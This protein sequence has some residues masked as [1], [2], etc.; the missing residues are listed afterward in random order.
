MKVN[1]GM[2]PGNYP[3]GESYSDVMA[4]NHFGTETIPPRPVLRIAAEK[5]IPKLKELK[6]DEKKSVI[7]TFIHNLLTQPKSQHAA[8]EQEFLRKV[9]IR[10]V[11]EAKLIIESNGGELQHNAPSTKAKKGFDHPL[12]ETGELMK[13]ISYEVEK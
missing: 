9:G 2:L 3:N 1:I 10:C 12:F 6:G 7:D 11:K 4:Y 8:L 5:T 13:H